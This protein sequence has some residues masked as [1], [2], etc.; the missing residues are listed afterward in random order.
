MPGVIDQFTNQTALWEKRIPD[1]ED[2]F[3]NPAYESGTEIR[4]RFVRKRRTFQTE[5]GK[6]IV[7]ERSI[8][9]KDQVK[10]GDRITYDGESFVIQVGPNDVI[11][12]DGTWWGAFCHG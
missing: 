7:T 12:L 8:L 6:I 4:V 9:T 1:S 10:T 3:G 5:P 11:W 2:A